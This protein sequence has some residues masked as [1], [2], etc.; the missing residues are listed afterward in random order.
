MEASLRRLFA[1]REW[2]ETPPAIRDWEGEGLARG[3]AEV[4]FRL[5]EGPL[6]TRWSV[7]DGASW[8]LT[9]IQPPRNNFV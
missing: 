8:S 6:T 4:R 5:D 3:R 9:S 1:R 2:A 7:R